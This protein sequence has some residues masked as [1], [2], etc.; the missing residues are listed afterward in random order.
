MAEKT[1]LEF[2]EMLKTD[3]TARELIKN[4]PKP[5]NEEERPAV[6]EE[7]AGK[8]GLDLTKEDFI[9]A[10]KDGEL[11][12]KARTENA[13]EKILELPDD[14]LDQVAGGK[15]DHDSCKDTF[16]D[17]EDCWYNDGCDTVFHSYKNY[18]CYW[19]WKTNSDPK[20]MHCNF[21]IRH[22]W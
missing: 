6:Y 19:D 17:K 2:F 9:R 20:D 16:R 4:T 14:A 5:N 12:Q 15:K 13:A 11:K 7:L 18:V 22:D 3:P 10:A 1:V 8:L 21:L